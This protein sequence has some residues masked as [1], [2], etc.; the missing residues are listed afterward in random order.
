MWKMEPQDYVCGN[1]YV[2][3]FSA[4]AV[5]L[6]KLRLHKG[7]MHFKRP[8]P[9]HFSKSL[10]PTNHSATEARKKLMQA[11][12]ECQGFP[13]GDRVSCSCSRPCNAPCRNC[14]QPGCRYRLSFCSCS[15]PWNAPAGIV[16]NWLRSTDRV[17]AVDSSPWKMLPQELSSTGCTA[18]RVSASCSSPWNA[19]AGIVV[20]WL[21][22]QIECP[23][24]AQGLGMFPQELSSTCCCTDWVSAV[25]QVLGMFPQKLW[26]T[27]CTTDWVSAVGQVLGMFPRE[28]SSTCSTPDRVSAVDS[29][30]WNVPA[31]IVVNLLC[32]KLSSCSWPSPWNVPAG[33]VVNW[34][35]HTLSVCS[36]PSPWNVPAGIVVNLFHPRSSVLQLLKSLECSRRNCRQLVAGS[37]RVS[38]V[39]Q[40]LGMRPQELSSTCSNPM[41]S[42]QSFF[43]PAK[44]ARVNLPGV[45]F[46]WS[47]SPAAVRCVRRWPRAPWCDCHADDEAGPQS[48][49]FFAAQE[50][51]LPTA[52]DV[53][54]LQPR[55]R[56]GSSR[57]GRCQSVKKK[58]GEI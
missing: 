30:P 52:A 21:L 19:P 29:S 6:P 12:E 48:V 38:A 32:F 53:G 20:N 16:V 22:D 25:A 28:L 3:F 58:N 51:L 34:L 27:G 13:Y 37:D 11:L 31:G 9:K 7:Q 18:D 15:S 42:H 54:A 4:L 47:R 56:W 5:A 41:L 36:W 2:K 55:A 35:Y 50:Q 8:V 10:R 43:S 44:V 46:G 49:G 33:I 39:A 17:S 57:L 14:R 1:W 23:A 26:S 24:V 40:G 45:G